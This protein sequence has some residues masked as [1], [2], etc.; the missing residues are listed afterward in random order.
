MSNFSHLCLI[1]FQANKSALVCSN[2]FDTMFHLDAYTIAN[3]IDL[4]SVILIEK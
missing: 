2:F 1:I 4:F 3:T